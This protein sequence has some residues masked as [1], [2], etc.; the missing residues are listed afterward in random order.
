M[1]SYIQNLDGVV[2]T[3]EK[4]IVAEVVQF[5]KSLL[6]EEASVFNDSFVF[7]IPRLISNEDDVMLMAPFSIQ[8]VKEVIF[9]MPS[10]KAPGIDGFIALFLK[11]YWPFLGEDPHLVLE[12]ARCNRSILKELNTTLIAIIPR[13]ENPKSFVDF[14]PISLCNTLYK[15]ITKAIFVQLANLIPKIVS[16]EQRGFVLG[17]EMTEGDIVA[18]EILHSISQLSI[19]DMILKLDMMKAYDRVSWQA[20]SCVLKNFGFGVK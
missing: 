10:D 5:F 6:S 14:H 8:E 17:R 18:H 20:L 13:L 2:I 1:I 15:I 3:E 11:K 4:E 16:G 9:S 7:A 12:E 19:L